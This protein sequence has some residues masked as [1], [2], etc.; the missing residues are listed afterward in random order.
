M[1]STLGKLAKYLWFSYR[2]LIYKIIE[3]IF[4]VLE[5]LKDTEHTRKYLCFAMTLVKKSLLP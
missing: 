3:M 4:A 1:I 2:S 5:T